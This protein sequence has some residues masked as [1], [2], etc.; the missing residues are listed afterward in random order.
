M[1]THR[2]AIHDDGSELT[3]PGL[4]GTAA[5]MRARSPAPSP[6]DSTTRT[7]TLRGMGPTV[8]AKTACP[9]CHV[10]H[11]EPIDPAIAVAFGIARTFV[12][13]ADGVKEELC[14]QHA[15]MV[16]LLVNELRFPSSRDD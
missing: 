16:K 5:P 2:R 12:K 13:G 7:R 6:A 3:S 9:C 11:D 8:P 14:G 4:G 15:G 10:K 1:N